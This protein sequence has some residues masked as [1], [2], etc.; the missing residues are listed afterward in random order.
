[1]GLDYYWNGEQ[2]KR[3]THEQALRLLAEKAGETVEDF[4]KMEKKESWKA[5]GCLQKPYWGPDMVVYDPLYGP[6]LY[7]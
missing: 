5:L 7:Y 6:K 4:L 3:L 2:M 1:M